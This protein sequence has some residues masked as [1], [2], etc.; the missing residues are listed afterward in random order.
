MLISVIT[1][2]LLV[3]IKGLMV[4]ILCQKGQQSYAMWMYYQMLLAFG[5][6]HPNA[7]VEKTGLTKST[8]ER[9]IYFL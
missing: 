7:R 3:R 8:E 4:V 1:S 6:L 5:V 9:V 2:T